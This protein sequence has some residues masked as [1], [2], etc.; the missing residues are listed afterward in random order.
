MIP[1][2]R[3]LCPLIF[4]VHV[5]C[6]PQRGRRVFGHRTGVG[7]WGRDTVLRS[8]RAI[9]NR[10]VDRKKWRWSSATGVHSVRVASASLLL[11]LL[12]PS[13]RALSFPES[14]RWRGT[15]AV[16][17]C[18]AGETVL[19]N[20]VSYQHGVLEN[21]CGEDYGSTLS[22]SSLFFFVHFVTRCTFLQRFLAA[23]P[24]RRWCL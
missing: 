18:T 12:F 19:F 20:D 15:N 2:V 11:S 8:R 6:F 14:V 1:R 7:G 24:R 3:I 16:L 17:P 22:L 5:V 23:S 13:P 4:G 21:A 9:G 10:S